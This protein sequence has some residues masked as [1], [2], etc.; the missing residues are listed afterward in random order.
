MLY[1]SIKKN[2]TFSRFHRP[3]FIEIHTI[4]VFVPVINGKYRI[5]TNENNT[6]TD[7]FS[8]TTTPTVSSTPPTNVYY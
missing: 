4:S 2:N 3:L 6:N 1:I 8:L 5:E 7:S